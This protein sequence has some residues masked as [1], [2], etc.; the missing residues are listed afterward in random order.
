MID[1]LLLLSFPVLFSICRKDPD[2]FILVWLFLSAFSYDML[3]V[4]GLNLRV[5]SFDR[6]AF[7]AS[8]LAM[9]ANGHFSKLFPNRFSRLEKA[10]LLFAFM[11]LLEAVMKFSPRDA[12]SLWTNA[13]D[14]YLLPFYFYL[15]TRYLLTRDGRYNDELEQR[16]VMTLAIVGFLCAAMS[17]FE[18]VTGIDLL[19]GPGEDGLRQEGGA[20][21]ANGPFWCPGVTGQYLSWILLL[22]MYRWR[23]R[24]VANSTSRPVPKVITVPYT[25]L[26][27]AGM[28]FVMFRNI[29][30]GFLGGC[31]IRYLFSRKGRLAFLVVVVLVFAGLMA[32]WQQFTKT[33]LYQE[34]IS[35]VENVYDR[36]GAWLYAFR[37]FSE[38]PLTG[39]GTLRMKQYI[40]GAQAAGDD[41]RVMDVPATY[42]P[43][44]TI[45]A[46]LAENGLL[47]AVPFCLVIWYFIRLV[48]ACV[49]LGQTPADVEFGLY[50]ISA[51]FAIYAPALT[52]RNLEYNKLNNLLWVIFALVTAHHAKLVGAVAPGLTGKPL[53]CTP[54]PE[55]TQTSAY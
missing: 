49:R 29:W 8:A 43:H 37:A 36:L 1:S 6:L 51:V 20:R 2:R 24:R 46:L 10:Y 50:A 15:F 48:R 25:L 44:N 4:F 13:L 5:V 12:F 40:R 18:G 41:L 3:I 17:I 45:I 9:I 35:N 7:L 28:Y 16:M 21:R 33:K 30:G 38:N 42:H 55:V 27:V 47:A 26:L 31:S 54:T 39:I 53:A 14:T 11:F 52:D 34:R 19:P 22:V 32:S 23:V